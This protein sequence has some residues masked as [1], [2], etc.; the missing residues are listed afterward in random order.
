MEV[1]IWVDIMEEETNTVVEVVST[2]VADM[3]GAMAIPMAVV[4]TT[5]VVMV[6][7]VPKIKAILRVHLQV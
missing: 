1:E 2:V 6:A 3:V 4:M 7:M 5:Q